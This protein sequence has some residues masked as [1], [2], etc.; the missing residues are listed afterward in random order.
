MIFRLRAVLFTA[1][2]CS[3]ALSVF[4]GP[5]PEVNTDLPRDP[6]VVQGTLPNG[7][8]Y[9]IR[10]NQEPRDRVTLR[11]LVAAGSLHERDDE[12]GLA[13][14]VEHMI[15]RGT[16]KHPGDSLVNALQR[17]G[18]GLGPDNTAFTSYDHTIYHLELPDTTSAS[19]RQG[20]ATFR[21]YAEDA[22]F[23]DALIER[24]RGVILSEKA[25]RDTPPYRRAE[26]RLAFLWPDSLHA[27]RPV[28]GVEPTLRAFK[29]EHFV[30]FYDAWYRPERLAVIIV[31]D[32]DPTA[33]RQLVED[34]FGSLTA[35]GPA[36]EEPTG[37]IPAKA[38]ASSVAIHLDPAEVG[39][40]ITFQHPRPRP[41]EA[42]THA[43][44]VAHLQRNLAFAMFQQR[45]YRA[46][47]D[48]GDA[49]V[50]PSAHV[51]HPVPGWELA[52]FSAS[53]R[54]NSWRA[55]ATAVEQEHRR[56]FLH[57]FTQSE[58]D[59]ARKNFLQYLAQNIRSAPTRRSESH[60][61]ELVYA[62]LQGNA[63]ATAE[64]YRDDL[65]SVIETA[66][67]EDCLR[68]FR[69]TWE[70]SPLHVFITAHPAFTETSATVASVLNT[71]RK[72]AVT[73]RTEKAAAPFAYTDFGPPGLVVKNE[74]QEALDIRL[75]RFANGVSLNFKPT[76]FTADEVV[77]FVRVEGGALTVPK[78]L[79]G[80]DLFADFALTRG[81][82]GRHNETEISELIAGRSIGLD[83][84]VESDAFVFSGRSSRRDLLLC[85][86]L[87]AAYL[88]DAGY[89]P[90]ATRAAHG[91]FGSLIS[92]L[93][94]SPGGPIRRH[95]ERKLM[96]GDI[97][98]GLP[99]DQVFYQR[100]L[101]ELKA[102]LQPAFANARI[103]MSIV[104]DTTW[105]EASAATAQ[106]FGA[107]PARPGPATTPK[108]DLPRFE[109]PP[110][111]PTL[112]VAPARLKQSAFAWY[113]PAPE[114]VGYRAERRGMMLA[115]IL[116]ERLRVRLREELGST[117][118]FQ[119][120]LE[121]DDGLPKCNH[122]MIY[123]EVDSQRTPEVINAL[124]KELDALQSRGISEDEFSR[125][126]IPLLRARAD[127]VR[128]N[129]Y[130]GHTVMLDPQQR[131]YRLEAAL[132]RT[133]DMNAVT[134]NE[135]QL[136][137]RKHLVRKKGFLFISEP[138]RV[139]KWDLK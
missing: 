71:S 101:D 136:L 93:E 87:I 31:G 104:G 66:T 56:A 127:D 98:F 85:L 55:L 106:T 38:S 76:A 99:G 122:F 113:F 73:A 62:L 44:R 10:R 120:S 61:A 4:A 57:G 39:I 1:W 24:E 119:A 79:S 134:R 103:E 92:Q 13:H 105:E 28:I 121:A 70:R 67:L 80:L 26:A 6:A 50:S 65:I 128:H 86:Q 68:G 58:L 124:R 110:R 63:V 42:D 125:V 126:K 84:S 3:L 17:L 83:F 114:I 25:V 52:A 30:A 16:R 132:N 123:A 96:G 138:G 90:E 111:A 22:T 131:P 19:L 49:L 53:G 117:Y 36:R 89:R 116:E 82:L 102:W 137:L 81:G 54:I 15:F 47:Q 112:Y 8:R 43:A 94:S 9:V 5:W 2:F 7:L 133:E 88:T 27:L 72:T 29:R 35:R 12:R 40:G 37:V 64:A 69:D 41:R 107:L 33:A 115:A 11:L 32:I 18:I 100:S 74:H 109:N 129:G 48:L 59:L 14:F 23:D 46:S 95:A 97:R 135:V 108:F 51:E 20:L 139:G 118:A 91:A 75:S 45:L 77:V 60:A 34:T 78:H 130:W 21:E